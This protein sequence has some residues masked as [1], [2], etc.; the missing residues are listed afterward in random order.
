M[1]HDASTI[2]PICE[3]MASI[4]RWLGGF[5]ASKHNKRDTGTLLV[6]FNLCKQPWDT[7]KRHIGLRVIFIKGSWCNFVSTLKRSFRA[8]HVVFSH[9]VYIL[10]FFLASIL[11]FFMAPILTFF[12]ASFLA[13]YLASIQTFYL[14]SILTFFSGIYSDI[15]SGILSDMG[16]ATVGTVGT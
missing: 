15:F 7:G 9:A 8:T 2:A 6:E 12:L 1:H 14:A 5:L 13:F 16:A 11:T 10:P 3:W 4:E